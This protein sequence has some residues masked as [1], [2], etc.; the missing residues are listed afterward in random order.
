MIEEKSRAA[1]E[2][3][4]RTLRGEIATSNVALTRNQRRALKNPLEQHIRTV[5]EL[6]RNCRR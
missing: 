4:I 3:V 2:D 1:R 6:L 5:K